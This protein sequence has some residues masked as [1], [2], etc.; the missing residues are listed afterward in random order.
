MSVITVTKNNFEEEVLNSEKTVL[1]DFWAS[2]CG[3]CK[4]LSP[5][6]D[7]IAEERDDIIVGKINVDSEPELAEKFGVFSSPTLVIL[8][9]G[10]VVHQSAG[11]RPKA[12]ILALLEG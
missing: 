7:E 3:P 8:K 6:I 5:I 10:K 4:M 11:A 2:W 1:L 12:Q 9:D